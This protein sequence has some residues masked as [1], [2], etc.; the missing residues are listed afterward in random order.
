MQAPGTPDAWLSCPAGGGGGCRAANPSSIEWAFAID[1]AS[2]AAIA[3]ANKGVR[4]D[5]QGASWIVPQH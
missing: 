1:A 2:R 5:A 4:K 3:A